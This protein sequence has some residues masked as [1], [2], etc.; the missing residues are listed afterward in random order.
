MFH[1]LD[2]VLQISLVFFT[3]CIRMYYRVRCETISKV[4]TYNANLKINDIRYVRY[5]ISISIENCKSQ[6]DI[7]VI[8]SSLSITSKSS[9]RPI[10]VQTNRSVNIRY[11][12]LPL[13]RCSMFIR[14][15]VRNRK[16]STNV[17]QFSQTSNSS[18]SHLVTHF[19][20][21]P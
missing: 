7:I 17:I 9:R 4:Y 1:C 21:A 16:E 10:E 2:Q 5:D 11:I 6:I 20:H 18:P 14:K 15:I 19:I 3:L 12:L 8:L 13:E